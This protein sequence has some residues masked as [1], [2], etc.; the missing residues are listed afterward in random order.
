MMSKKK[1]IEKIRKNYTQLYTLN[2]YFVGK[3][4]A[5]SLCKKGKN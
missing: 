1:N 2:E 3:K 4:L 5:K